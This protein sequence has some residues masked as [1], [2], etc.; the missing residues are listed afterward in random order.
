VYEL[1]I[2]SADVFCSVIE[3]GVEPV[4]TLKP[5]ALPGVPVGETVMYLPAAAVIEDASEACPS[6]PAAFT[7][8]TLA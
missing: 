1:P 4:Y 5:L 8:A 7:Q 2:E 6:C 3:S